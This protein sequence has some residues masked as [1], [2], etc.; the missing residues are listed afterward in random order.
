MP[1]SKEPASLEALWAL[2][3]RPAFVPD[4]LAPDEHTVETWAAKETKEGRFVSQ[5]QA[6]ALLYDAYKAGRLTRRRVRL[7]AGS[8]GGCWAYRPAKP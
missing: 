6:S 3:V 4:A 7:V 8:N 2:A 1:R 5:H